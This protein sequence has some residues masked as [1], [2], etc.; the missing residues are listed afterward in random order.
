[1]VSHLTR[2]GRGGTGRHTGL[3]ILRGNAVRVRFPPSAPPAIVPTLA[4]SRNSAVRLVET[5]ENVEFLKAAV[6]VL[7]SR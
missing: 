4:G 1:M 5:F 7:P 6:D 3:K 2:R